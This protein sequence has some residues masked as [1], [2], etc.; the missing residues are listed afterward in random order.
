VRRPLAP[1][2]ASGERPPHPITPIPLS[3]RAPARLPAPGIPAGWLLKE[4]AGQVDTELVRDEVPALR[5]R[6]RRASYALYRDVAVDVRAHPWLSWSWKVVRLPAGGDVRIQG[7]DDQAAQLYVVFPRWPDPRQSSEVIGYV[8]DTAAPVG[9]R[10]V[11]ARAANVRVVVV[12]S[13]PVGLET[14]RRFERNV[15]Q[16]YAS[17]FGRQPPRAGKVALMIDSDDTRSDA[18]VLVADIRFAASPA[19]RRENPTSMLR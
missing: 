3:D 13:G 17:L 11:N 18:E 6:S 7:S 16:D 8:W 5:L 4:F 10:S 14:W 19:E 12:A 9:H 1:A 15:E 2:R